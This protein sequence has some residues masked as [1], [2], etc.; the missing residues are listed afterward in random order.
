MN[1]KNTLSLL[2][3]FVITISALL[4]ISGTVSADEQGSSNGSN[5]TQPSFE[6]SPVTNAGFELAVKPV[7]IQNSG[8]TAVTFE[9][10]ELTFGEVRDGWMSNELELTF[11]PTGEIMTTS[12]STAGKFVGSFHIMTADHEPGELGNLRFNFINGQNNGRVKFDFAIYIAPEVYDNLTPG[13]YNLHIDFSYTWKNCYSSTEPGNKNIGGPIETIIQPMRVLDPADPASYTLSPGK[14]TITHAGYSDIECSFNYLNLGKV[15]DNNGDEADA[16]NISFT[17]ESGTLTD[18]KNHSVAFE[19]ADTSHTFHGK[20]LI[21]LQ[22]YDSEDDTF[23]IPIYIKPTDYYSLPAGTYSGGAL[24]C[25]AIWGTTSNTI[26]NGIPHYIFLE[27]VIPEPT[28]LATGKCGATNSDDLTWTL[29]SNGILEITGTGAMKNYESYTYTAPWRQYKSQIACVVIDSGITQIGKCAFY[30]CDKVISVTIP[31]TVTTIG[32][33]AF[34]YCKNLPEVIIPNS[35]TAIGSSAFSNCES[36]T[37][38]N[39]P[40]SVTVMGRMAFYQSGLKTVSIGKGL[41]SIPES[42]F[43]SAELTSVDIPDTVTTIESSAFFTCYNLKSVTLHDGL[44]TI[45]ENA[46]S[47]SAITSITIPDTV[48]SIG[49]SAFSNCTS[50]TSIKLSSRLTTIEDRT[51]FQCKSLESVTIPSGVTSI[52]INAFLT[53]SNLASVDLPDGLKTIGSRAFSECG[54]LTTIDLPSGLESIGQS[55]FEQSGLTSVVIPDSVNEIGKSTFMRCT[56]LASATLPK[57]YAAIPE[58]M[59]EDCEALKSIEIPGCVTT[60]GKNAFGDCDSLTSV[61]I[62]NSVTTIGEEAFSGCDKLKSVELPSGITSIARY[63]FE[64]CRKLETIRIPQSVT[65][66]D[67]GAF[68]GCESLTYVGV[69]EKLEKIDGAAFWGCSSLKTFVIPSTVTYIGPLAFRGCQKVTDVYCYA[70]PDTL[71]W[72]VGSIGDFKSNNETKCHVLNRLN[73]YETKFSDVQVTFVLD[74][75]GMAG[76]VYLSGYTLSLEGD[77]G[78]NFYIQLSGDIT[79]SKTSKVVFT[80]STLDGS[81]TRT[82]TVYV[83][84]QSDPNLAYSKISPSG[85]ANIFKCNVAAKEMT[86]KVTA[87]VYN[88]GQAVGSP[89]TYSVQEYAGRMLDNASVYPNEQ[90]LIKAMLNYGTAAQKYF[91]LNETNYA[92]SILSANDQN[93]SILNASEITGYDLKD[94]TE[95]IGFENVSLIL[96]SKTAMKIFIKNGTF[97]AD[98]EF[99]SPG[100]KK[101]KTSQSGDYTVVLMDGIPAGHLLSGNSVNI[102]SGGKVVGHITYSPASYCK[103]IVNLPT[104]Q[105]YTNE[106]K[107]TVSTLYLYGKEAKAYVSK[108]N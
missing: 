45:G 49:D 99:R 71:T 47:A 62:P 101:Y 7:N 24:V 43:S 97:P 65:V 17:V 63:A 103:V 59:F 95:G 61:K 93:T 19:L 70:S 54:S 6:T 10:S 15:I 31:N 94:V 12:G 100:G 78:L 85:D 107:A 88:N 27:L 3:A 50:L 36:L 72:E 83:N 58:S 84:P 102:I 82:Q 105:V 51:F 20:N 69:P 104:D 25:Q 76:Y 5:D 33:S 66:L 68:Y 11:F 4:A 21:D 64:W 28:V 53:C 77:I 91:G 106:L 32:D 38:I 67:Y 57:N 48:T 1:K 56:A 74:Q 39:I 73:D 13:N 44:T 98:A 46:F 26:A 37:A 60:I 16:K 34:T 8:F 41:T 108:S 29:Y 14:Y 2:L 86:S 35:V 9:F 87:Q 52:G 80:I 42:A 79:S 40:D 18:G 55:A 81:K 75:N 30:F 90:P 96:E 23:T 92:N 89:Y 22:S